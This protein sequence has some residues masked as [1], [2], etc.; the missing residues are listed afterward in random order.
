MS[1]EQDAALSGLQT[2]I[3]ME[4]DGK[5]FYSKTAKAS[6]NAYGRQL[7]EK[8]AQEEDIH[9][10]VFKNIYEAIKKKLKWPDAKFVPDGGRELKTLFSEAVKN[11]DS[12]YRPVAAELDAVKTGMD[13]EN[14]TLDFYRSRSAKA[15]HDA[16]KQLYDALASEES[17]HFQV[18]QDYYDFLNNPVDYYFRKEHTSVDGG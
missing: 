9:R 3:Q 15:G 7:L 13:M 8:L 6:R 5:E 11:I 2:A 4:I 14:K 16:E 18:L 10:Q 17:G 1:Q 12:K